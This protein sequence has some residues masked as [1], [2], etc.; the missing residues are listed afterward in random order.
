MR[1]PVPV[2]IGTLA[3]GGLRVAGA[4]HR[5]GDPRARPRSRSAPSRGR[6]TTSCSALRRGGALADLRPRDVGGRRR[7]RSR[8]PTCSGCTTTAGGS[9]PMPGVARVTSVVNLPGHRDGGRRGRPFW[10]AVGKATSALAP[11]GARRREASGPG[12]PGLSRACSAPSSARPPALAARD[13]GAGHDAL[14]RWSRGAAVLRAGAGA[15]AVRHPIS[16]RTTGHDRP[17]RRHL[18]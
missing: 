5:V 16:R 13:H 15:R 1:H 7:T 2:L 4:A 12:L 8:R 9:R 6:A 17:R 11:P 18:A 14:P 10:R 3:S